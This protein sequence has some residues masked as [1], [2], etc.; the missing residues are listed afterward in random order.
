[1]R[2]GEA[3]QRWGI[4]K[5]EALRKHDLTRFRVEDAPLQQTFVR[6][7]GRPFTIKLMFLAAR[8]A[9]ARVLSN[10]FWIIHQDGCR[11]AT[12]TTT[13]HCLRIFNRF[14]NDRARSQPDVRSAKQ[15]S[16]DLLK[17]L[18]VWLL[19]KRRFKRKTAAGISRMSCSFL[20]K[21]RRVH[22]ED[23]DPSFSIPGNM[24]PG[25]DSEP[26]ESKALPL[27]AFQKIL[28]VAEQ[29]V[30]DI[31][32]AY[33]SGDVPTSSQ[34]LIPFM[35]MIAAR[36]G[37]NADALY[38]LERDCLVPHEFDDNLFYCVWDK[39][40]AGK[41]Q[42]QLHRVDRR[43]RMG[44]VE[45]IQFLQQ[46][47]EPLALQ[48]GPPKNKQLFLY[49]SE[50][51]Q[52][53]HRLVSPGAEPRLSFRRVRDFCRRH[54]LP[55]FSLSQIR[56]SAATLLYLQ[57]GGNLGKVQQFL[58]HAHLHTT[59]RYVLNSITE[60]FNA[61][62]IQKAQE[63]MIERITVIPENREVGV[64]CLN[65]PKGQALKIV[66]GRFDT[67]CGV[68]RDPYD[69]PQPGEAKGR[70]CTSFHA[71]FGCPNG[72]WFLEDLP[73]V[74]AT[75]DRFLRLQSEMKPGD[76]EMVYGSSLRIIEENILPAFRPEQIE[77]AKVKAR[78][79]EQKPLVVAKGVLG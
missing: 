15:L 35:I 6:P 43:K 39:P 24:F 18:A 46:Y 42:R 50:N 75:R 47:T 33:K 5:S 72:L 57:T 52:L 45:L 31:Q 3:G 68:C 77:M 2:K 48:A 62:A 54:R 14:L 9:L 10:T 41:Q 79:L 65:L 64:R 36:T 22:P 16:A 67:G 44:V 23:F 69:S 60:S 12:V 49:F 19:V 8:P 7:D 51:S 61:R 25:V 58:Q 63:R 32:Q 55:R 76:W 78:D 13:A 20:R 1:M 17:E 30:G 40:R 11:K 37:I 70:A 66:A 28:G 71:C 73:L 53:K 59:V 74:I 34:Q 4:I 56:P 21:A 29:Q 26:R 38:S 27:G